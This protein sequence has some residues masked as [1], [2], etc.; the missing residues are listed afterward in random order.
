MQDF[1]IYSYSNAVAELL[2][3]LDLSNIVLVGHSF[4][5]RVSI[6][7]ASQLND[8]VRKMILIDSAGLKPRNSI[9]KIHRKIKYKFAKFLVKINFKNKKSLEKY[10]SYDYR[11]LSNEEKKVFN[12]VVNE[13]LEKYLSSIK[14]QTLIVWGEKDKDTPLYMAK[15]LN[16]KITNSQLYVVK[17]SGHFAYVDEAKLVNKIIKEFLK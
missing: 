12:R 11:Q 7:L 5:G 17:N 3:Q 15:F 6:I 10:G 9:K 16:K 13:Y 8:I 2:K 4:G 14:C 1:D